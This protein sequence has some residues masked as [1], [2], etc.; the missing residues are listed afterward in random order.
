MQL[1]QISGS[2]VL[3]VIIIAPFLFRFGFYLFIA[4]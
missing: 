1:A 2:S 3:E 4:N